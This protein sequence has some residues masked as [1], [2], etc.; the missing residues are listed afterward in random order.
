MNYLISQDGPNF[1]HISL[2]NIVIEVCFLIIGSIVEEF[3]FYEP[4]NFDVSTLPIFL[5]IL[6]KIALW[7]PNIR[8]ENIWITCII[9]SLCH[10]PKLVIL[11][12]NLYGNYKHLIGIQL[13]A[14]GLY[15]YIIYSQSNIWIAILYHIIGN[16]ICLGSYWI[17]ISRRYRVQITRTRG[18]YSGI[19]MLSTD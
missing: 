11:I 18:F 19:M 4:I 1:I 13:I 8:Y 17:L 7:F 16:T 2:I 14:L 5:L 6:W 3:I 9:F 10:I 15:R 12:P